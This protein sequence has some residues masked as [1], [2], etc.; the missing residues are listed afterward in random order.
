LEALLLYAGGGSFRYIKKVLEEHD[1][2]GLSPLSPFLN[3]NLVEL[4]PALRYLF[5]GRND[6]KGKIEQLHIGPINAPD[7][8]LTVMVGGYEA[9][10]VDED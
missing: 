8:T 9:Y 5:Y 10:K 7:D 3:Q 1:Q 6:I 4:F 2:T